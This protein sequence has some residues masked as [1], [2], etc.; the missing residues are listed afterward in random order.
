MKGRPKKDKQ[1]H[2]RVNDE[3]IKLL[4]KLCKRTGRSKTDMIRFALNLY[5][6]MSTPQKDYREF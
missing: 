2:F 1:I 3:D 4:D 5:D 6:R